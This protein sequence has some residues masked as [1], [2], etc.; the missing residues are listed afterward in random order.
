[1]PTFDWIVVGNGLTGAALSYELARQGVS[2]LLL[3]KS[4]TPESATRY[5]YAGVP[6]WSGS[7]PLLRQLFRESRTRYAALPE[8]TGVAHHY[9]E[10]DLLLTVEPDQDPQDLV[11]RY[12]QVETPPVP[13]TAAEAVEREPLLNPAAIAGALTVRHG[14]VDPAALVK[15]Y[16]H[17]LQNLGGQI[18]I[19]TVTGL[20]RIGDRITGVTTPTQAYAAGQVVVAA[21]GLTRELIKTAGIRVPVYFTHAEVVETPPLDLTLRSLIM[22][23]DLTRS[24]I[25]SEATSDATQDLW[26][27]PGNEIRPPFLDSGCVQFPDGRLRMGQI[28][29]I[30]TALEPTLDVTQGERRIRAGITPLVPALDQVPGQWHACRVAFSQDGLPLAGPVPGLQRGY[31]F[32]G[33]TSPF[34]LVPAMAEHFARWANG[35]ASDVVQATRPDR[36]SADS[37]SA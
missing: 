10:L 23:A 20:V 21:G 24:A 13:I 12:A 17:G 27:E 28:S 16:N 14:H 32:S 11:R 37:L 8:E 6:H 4:V 7:S 1:M 29:R 19:A 34:G 36:F 33:F 22:P 18:I 15:V 5:S 25:E 3:E 9:R 31:V 26:D 35:Q 30:N 2:V